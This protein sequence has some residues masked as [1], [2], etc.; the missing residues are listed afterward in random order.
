MSQYT[1]LVSSWE[2]PNFPGELYTAD[3][4]PGQEEVN[5]SFLTLVGGINGASARIVDDMTY[6]MTVEFDYPAA[7]QPDISENTSATVLPGAINPIVTNTRN[8]CQIYQEAVAETYVSKATR[9][10]LV[11][12]QLYPSGAPTEGW[13]SEFSPNRDDA[14]ITSQVNY[15]LGRIARNVNHTFLNGT[16]HESNGKS[17]AS[18]TR[19]ILEGITTNVVDASGAALSDALTGTLFESMA[20]KSSGKA[21]QQLPI[22]LMS[23]KQK[24][25]F[26]ALFA[27]PPES[28]N[29]AGYN[30]TM[31]ETDFGPVGIMYE[32]TIADNT[33]LFASLSLVK[34]VYNEVPGKG[35]LFYEP[36]AQVGA[37]EGGMLYGHIG[38]DYG[39]E[40]MHGKI[41]NLAV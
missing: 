35:I 12:D 24:R 34:P 26:S 13:I 40:W 11:T 22:L 36:K 10:R 6:S 32:P 29:V 20:T 8:T 30:I 39:A 16:F 21:F 37:S 3:V 31:F 15:A 23:A 27:F 41:T 14:A 9:G 38:L 25:K 28:R 5:P 4:V 33:I 17:D 18:R 2:L 7:E 1:G 19:G